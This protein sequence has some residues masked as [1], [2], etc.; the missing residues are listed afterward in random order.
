MY[1]KNLKR[2]AFIIAVSTSCFASHAVNSVPFVEG[3]SS[4]IT[5]EQ[6]HT[7]REKLNKLEYF[8]ASFV[9][10]IY[11]ED[12]ETLQRAEGSIAVAK[13][14]KVNWHTKVPDETQIISDGKTLWFYD[15]F[16]EQATAFNVEDSIANTPILLI[17][18]NDASV[19]QK[20]SVSQTSDGAYT[21]RSND[22]NSR[23]EMLVIA[24]DES[25]LI[26]RF[27]IVDSTGQTSKIELANVNANIQPSADS[28]HFNLPDGVVLDD[29]R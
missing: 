6:K 21:V 11:D 25:D 20:F 18:N 23:V 14:N 3:E 16:V 24:F 28:F 15:P 26:K 2:V 7:L 12:G 1:Q 29:Q 4:A 10:T 22:P 17:T 9:Q 8:S 27:D 5:N 19:W 13:P